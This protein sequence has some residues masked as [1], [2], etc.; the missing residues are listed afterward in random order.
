VSYSELFPYLKSRISI[1]NESTSLTELGLE[2]KSCSFTSTFWSRVPSAN[3]YQGLSSIFK[4]LLKYYL[5]RNPFSDD[6]LYKKLETPDEKIEENARFK[7]LMFMPQKTVKATSVIIM[8][9]GLNERAWEKYLP[10]A[11]ELVRLTGSSVLLFPHAFHMNRAPANWSDHRLMGSIAQER[12]VLFPDIRCSTFANAAISTRLQLVPSRFVFSGLQTIHDIERLTSMI[13][14]GRHPFIADSAKLDIFGYSIG[15][16]IGE[17]ILLSNPSHLYD[18]SRL[19]LFCGG[20]TLDQTFPTSRSILDSEASLAINHFYGVDFRNHLSS[21]E[22]LARIFEKNAGETAIF[23]FMIHSQLNAARRFSEFSRIRDRLRAVTFSDDKVVP[24]ASV[25]NT[26]NDPRTLRP[27][28]DRELHYPFPCSHEV[29][30]PVTESYRS[31]IDSSF[32]ETFELMASFLRP[33]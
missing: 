25:L 9:H 2:V 11:T 23:S 28:L 13:R 22:R 5:A 6:Y 10:W 30:F 16:F 20:A 32:R 24:T 3:E 4:A 29:P 31:M 14:E 33:T 27:T 26:I 1:N 19:L 15:G 21:D 18:D 17:I 7:Y 8:L 12:K